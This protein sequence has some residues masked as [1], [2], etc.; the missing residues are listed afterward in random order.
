MRYEGVSGN[1]CIDLCI[2]DVNTSW[3]WVISF[4]FRPLYPWKVTPPIPIVWEWVGLRTGLDDVEC[5]KLSP[6]TGLEIYPSAAQ[7]VASHYT[8]WATRQCHWGFEEVV[9]CLT[10]YS[11]NRLQIYVSVW[12][13]LRNAELTTTYC[14]ISQAFIVVI[15]YTDGLKAGWR[16]YDAI[17]CILLPLLF[18]LN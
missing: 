2:L 10:V 15:C 5:R 8:D 7:P 18:T 11:A 17:A 1:G 6:L 3:R 12:V 13:K 9:I 16:Y 14:S 4:T